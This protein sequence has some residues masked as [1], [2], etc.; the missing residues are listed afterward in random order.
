MM[1]LTL[2]NEYFS[3]SYDFPKS[4]L[5]YFYDFPSTLTCP[6]LYFFPHHFKIVLKGF[7]LK[8]H[9]KLFLSYKRQIIFAFL[10]FPSFLISIWKPYAPCKEY[11]VRTLKMVSANWTSKYAEMILDEIKIILMEP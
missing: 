2:L 11:L 7:C 10:N 1:I 5:Q 8:L 6:R 4:F 9:Q 3:N